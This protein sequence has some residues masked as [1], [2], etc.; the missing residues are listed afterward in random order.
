M[1]E[2]TGVSKENLLKVYE[3]YAATGKPDKA[4]TMLYALGWTQHTVGVQNIRLAGIIQLLLG[5]FGVAGG[6]IN[7]LRGEP[8]VQGSTDHALLYGYIP[9][10]PQH[11]HRHLEDPGRVPE[12]QHPGHR[13]PHEREL[14]EQPAQVHRQPAQGLVRRLRHQGKRLRLCAPA[15][16]R[17]RQDYS[18]LFIFDRMYQGKI[19]GGF[20]FGH[21][22]CQS[23]PNSNKV[24][25]AWDKLD[26]LVVGEVFHN[27]STDNFRRPGAD[28]KKCKT[29]I[30]LLPSAYRAEKE[31]TI[32]NS[33]RWHMWHYKA[34]EPIGQCKSMGDMFVQI[35][36]RVRALY[37]KEGG[38]LPD[39][40]LKHELPA[41][42]NAEEMCQEDQ[43]LLHPRHQ[44]RAT[45][46][47]RKASWFPASR[48]SRSMAP[49]P[50]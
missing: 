34:I 18:H 26:W 11:A 7:A 46:S 47:T 10:L 44:N 30:F 22:P 9:G 32:S 14:V 19:K 16:A 42:F 33:G 28:P 21:N 13:R 35:M 41:T 45:R 27:E 2:V 3:A 12:G 48:T 29:E 24:R 17:P 40:V 43:R 4:G 31:G 39:Q 25:K 49:R 6:G 8:N 50:A 15:Q 20:L 23:F 5:N 37:A 36:G 38:A 1:S